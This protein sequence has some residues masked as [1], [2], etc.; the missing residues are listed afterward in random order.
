[1]NQ[2][3]RNECV[4]DP[5][6]ICRVCGHECLRPCPHETPEDYNEEYGERRACLLLAGHEEDC[7]FW[8]DE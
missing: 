2:C 7:K 3:P 6:G 5:V 4:P 1:M 8:E